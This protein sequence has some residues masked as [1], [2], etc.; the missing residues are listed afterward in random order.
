MSRSE[1]LA[2]F[3]ASLRDKPVTWG[4]DDCCAWVRV[5]ITRAAHMDVAVPAYASRRDAQAIIVGAGGLPAL[6][7]DLAV[8]HGLAPTGAPTLGDVGLVEMSFGPA[9]VIFATAGICCVRT[10]T[11][12]SFMSPRIS[13]IVGAW[14]VP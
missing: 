3:V 1:Q 13:T 12:V 14:R 9:G 4:V 5:W 6:W 2:E 8:R 7:N 11:G 10:D